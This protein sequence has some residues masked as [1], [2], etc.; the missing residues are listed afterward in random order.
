M[1]LDMDAIKQFLNLRGRLQESGVIGVSI[2]EDRI[3]ID[4]DRFPLI[5]DLEIEERTDYEFPYKVSTKIDGV[6][7]YAIANK[8]EVEKLLRRR[9]ENETLRTD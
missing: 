7:F 1:S 6:S 2:F 5:N 8:N 4:I 3:H 9:K